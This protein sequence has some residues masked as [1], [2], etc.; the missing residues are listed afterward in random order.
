MKKLILTLVIIATFAISVNATIWT[1]SNMPD[2][3]GQY[4]SLQ[5]AIDTAANG[6]TI[7]VSGSTNSYGNIIINKEIHLF[8]AGY[9][10]DK[11]EAMPSTLFAINL[12][13]IDSTDASY[14]SIQGFSLNNI[15]IGPFSGTALSNIIIRRNSIGAFINSQ[16]THNLQIVNNIIGQVQIGGPQTSGLVISNNVFLDGWPL[17]PEWNQCNT[18]LI[19][20]NLFISSIASGISGSDLEQALFLK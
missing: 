8:G 12:A 3:P 13:E 18:V 15:Q 17:D 14:S 4:T 11:Q 20:N 5:A 1:V 19:S 7:Y 16:S 9:N 6:D 10:P 2:S